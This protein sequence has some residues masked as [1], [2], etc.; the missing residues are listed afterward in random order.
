MVSLVRRSNHGLRRC[1]GSGSRQVQANRQSAGAARAAAIA[2]KLSATKQFH[3]RFAL[4]R[5]ASHAR[6]GL[7]YCQNRRKVEALKP[8]G[9][10]FETD[11]LQPRNVSFHGFGDKTIFNRSSFLSDFQIAITVSSFEVVMQIS[12]Q[13][14]LLGVFKTNFLR[15]Q[16]SRSV[17]HS[18]GDGF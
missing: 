18:A 7:L 13:V 14:L 2:S 15:Q 17:Q 16:Q 6:S 1:S 9:D 3:P 8:R 11:C 5:H 4:F 10:G 12:H